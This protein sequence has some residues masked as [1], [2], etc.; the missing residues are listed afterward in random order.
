M[1]EAILCVIRLLVMSVLDGMI[2]S[3]GHVSCISIVHR[4]AVTCVDQ[5]CA[6]HVYLQTVAEK[7]TIGP[8]HFPDSA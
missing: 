8:S 7:Y 6:V 1:K 5:S 2:C 3:T 4:K